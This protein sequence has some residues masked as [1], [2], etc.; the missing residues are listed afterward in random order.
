MPKATR[1]VAV[2]LIGAVLLP[3]TGSSMSRMFAA[4]QS[5][6]SP[7]LGTAESFRVLGASTV[8]NTGP[9]VVNGDLGVKPGTAVTGFPPGIVVPPGKIYAGVAVAQKAQSD[10]TTAYNAL[11]GQACNVDLT[12]Q[13]LGGLTLTPGV[14]CFS[15][16]AQLTGA[17]TLNA[18][19]DPN[20]VFIFKIGST[21]TTASNSSVIV[22][23]GGS[24]CNVF[25]QV[26]SSATLGTSTQ[27]EGNVLALVS[28]TLNT[29]VRLNGRALARTG[30]VTL[31]SNT[32]S[33]TCA[34]APV[35]TNTPV[36]V[37]TN[38][39]VPV[40][41]FTPV[42]VPTNTSV[43]LPT[44]TPVPSAVELLY[45][46][47]SMNGQTVA[48]NWATAEEVDNYGFNLYRAPVDDFSQAELI[49]F[50][51]SDI[52]GGSSSGATY[53]YLDAPPLQGAWWYWLADIDT[54]GIQS[55]HIS[56][57]VAVQLRFQVYLPWTGKQ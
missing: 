21:L 50:E 22:I 3:V 48:L 11:T 40:P 17:L 53:Q 46:V 9:T 10:V 26:G 42:S 14:Y 30:A 19:G 47:A 8:T 34:A 36:P 35:S 13:D 54:H 29:S 5:G 41:T 52:Q 57:A 43:P 23:N 28:I 44:N 55:S 12:G 37:S 15:T 27:F 31:D 49:H 6:V 33:L 39:P 56:V 1:L 16:S 18:L 38:T 25:W 20:A 45:F 7:T 51:P 24:T 4:P 32:I 2:L